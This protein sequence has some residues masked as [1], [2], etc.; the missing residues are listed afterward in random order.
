MLPIGSLE[1]V[2]CPAGVADVDV[3]GSEIVGRDSLP[4]RPLL[5][6]LEPLSPIAAQSAGGGRPLQLSDMLCARPR[7]RAGFEIGGGRV[8]F[9]AL[10]LIN[11]A[12]RTGYAGTLAKNGKVYEGPTMSLTTQDPAYSGQPPFANLPD[13]AVGWTSVEMVDCNTLK[14]TLPFLG[15][16]FGASIWEPG[17]PRTGI[18]WMPN[19]K[20]SLLSPP[21]VDLIPILTGDTRPIVETY[22]RLPETVNPDLLHK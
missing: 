13:V 17:T 12:G 15:V 22:H 7:Q 11:H 10:Q 16:C 9:P 20:I 14:S 3:Y 2:H 21:D 5:K 19:A 18:N 6:D 1:H 4:F 8:G